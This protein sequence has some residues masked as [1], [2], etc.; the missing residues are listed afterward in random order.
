MVRGGMPVR[1]RRWPPL[2]DRRTEAVSEQQRRKAARD[3]DV[4]LL[5]R[6]HTRGPVLWHALRCEQGAGGDCAGDPRADEGMRAPDRAAPTWQRMMRTLNEVLERGATKA[7]AI[8]VPGGPRLTYGQLREQVEAAAD[9]LAQLGLGR[10][11][12]IAL[13]LPNSVET[14]VLFLAAAAT[15]TA[16]PLNQAYKEDEFRFY[17]EDTEA[18]ALIVP[19]GGA[20]AARRALPRGVL[21]VEASLDERGI[22]VL[23]SD[24]PRVRSRSAERPDGDDVALVLHTSGTTSRPKLVPLRHRNLAYSA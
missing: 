22:M 7:T 14:I 17:L 19:P 15:G 2:H 21:L 12:R 8:A 18:R 4:H 6:V 10:G 20:P 23:D 11:Q 5:P 24:A 3:P 16:A 1:R 9:G 13:V